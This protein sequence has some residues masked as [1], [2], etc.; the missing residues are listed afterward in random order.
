MA[1]LIEIHFIK[2]CNYV[3]WLVE[4]GRGERER[5]GEWGKRG[6]ERGRK[7]RWGGGGIEREVL[8]N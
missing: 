3:S 2:I 6:M 8:S 7:G 1:T 4:K 5:E